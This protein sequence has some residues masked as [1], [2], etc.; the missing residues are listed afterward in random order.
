M[1][2]KTT[3]YA[4]KCKRIGPSNGAAWLDSIQRSAPY[5]D[6]P[7]IGSWLPGTQSAATGAMKRVRSAFGRMKGG[8]TAP[9]NTEDYD[10]MTH[11]MGISCIRAGQIAGEE[12][13]N[14]LMLPP[15]IA[16]NLALRHVL[17][18]RRKWGK[19]EILPAESEQI[20]WAIEIYETI[21]QASSP[22]QLTASVD[23]RML[24]LAGAVHESLEIEV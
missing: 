24:V 2:R 1:S 12:A 6:E 13:E 7:I 11:A 15:L 23:L 18:R 19:W 16:S 4:R 21:V 17:A 22:T 10:L 5:S 14:N 9:N 8:N 20:D 3:A